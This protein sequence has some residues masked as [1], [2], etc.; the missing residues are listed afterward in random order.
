MFYNFVCYAMIMDLFGL[1]DKE[2]NYEASQND[3]QANFVQ[4]LEWNERVTE[5][6]ISVCIP[7]NGVQLITSQEGEIQ[8]I[9]GREEQKEEEITSQ[10]GNL[11]TQHLWNVPSTSNLEE[12]ETPAKDEATQ[13]VLQANFVQDVEW[14]ES[15][16]EEEIGVYVP[17]NNVQLIGGKEGEIQNI[18]ELEGQKIGEITSQQSNLDIQN[19]WSVPSTSNLEEQQETVANKK[20]R[21]S[22]K[23]KQ[24]NKSYLD[25]FVDEEEDEDDVLL[26]EAFGDLSDS[27]WSD[28]EVTKSKSERINKRK[29]R[30][31]LKHKGEKYITKNGKEKRERHLQIN[32]CTSSKCGNKCGVITEEKRQSIFN[33]FQSLTL[34]ERR[35]WIVNNAV[36]TNVKRRRVNDS[37]PKREKTVKYFI[38]EGESRRQVCRQFLVATLD[39]S[40]KFIAYTVENSDEG[41]AKQEGRGKHIPANK[42]SPQAIDYVKKYI[43]SLPALPSHYCRKETT[44][45]YLSQDFKNPSHLYRLYKRYLLEVDKQDLS[46]LVSESI[47][48]KIFVNDFNISFHIPKKR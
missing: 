20:N 38:N 22:K 23:R 10:Q 2:Q 47:F 45:T 33:Y 5:D 27:E 48:K 32:P 29:E 39:V 46:L 28:V 6:E 30:K 12:Q 9:L 4:I 16:T 41:F 34:Q 1:Q 44:R 40:R 7:Q 13:N 14:N 15:V 21:T 35:N 26:K 18:L 24:F 19:L 36:I 17:E 8:N 3:L 11:D 25:Y 43:S 31:L 37:E 42:T